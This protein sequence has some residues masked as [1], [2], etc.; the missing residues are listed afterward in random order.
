MPLV[1][2]VHLLMYKMNAEHPESVVTPRL[3]AFLDE[4][5]SKV[6][7]P[8]CCCNVLHFHFS[9]CVCQ[10]L[11]PPMYGVTLYL[12]CVV[13]HI[14][15]L[16]LLSARR[17]RL[18]QSPAVRPVPPLLINLLGIAVALATLALPYLGPDDP[19]QQCGVR[20]ACF[21]YAFKLL[22]LALTKATNPP[23]LRNGKPNSTGQADLSLHVK[24]VWFLLSD[25]RY[26]HFNIEVVQKGRPSHREKGRYTFAALTLVACAGA[27]WK[28]P[29]AETKC[30]LLLCL[31]QNTLEGLHSL[32]HP[33][34][35]YS[36][37]YRP[38]AAASLGDFW[39]THWH[40]SAVFLQSLAY[41]PGRKLLGRWFGVL[42][43]FAMSGLWH[44]WAA[45]PLVD[46]E[47]SVKLGLQVWVFFVMLGVG[48]LLERL[49]WQ[50]QQGGILQR[51][52]VWSW[53][54]GWAGW[55][56]RTLE[57]H[58]RIAFLKS[59]NFAC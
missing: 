46:D 21:F 9:R 20:V 51:V 44:G 16:S 59:K 33:R 7:A 31:I 38:F 15:V 24:Y 50:K 41:R 27:A 10:N 53:A 57:C 29:I 45:A 18:S 19:L 40:A 54:L 43:A 49:I 3:R 23:T 8:G 1:I 42:A 5:A 52:L 12:L 34:C 55:C 30:L 25:M 4:S 6:R 58:S 56:F 28:L 47:Y 13:S 39:T 14:Q 11:F 37:F 35:P 2:S 32:L 26:R 36:L 22:D 48:T 17:W